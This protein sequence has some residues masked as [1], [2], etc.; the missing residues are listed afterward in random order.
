MFIAAFHQ[1]AE[2]PFTKQTTGDWTLGGICRPQFSSPAHKSLQAF[3]AREP[4]LVQIG[5]QDS[6]VALES[7]DV[8]TYLNLSVKCMIEMI[9]NGLVA[10]NH[11]A[12]YLPKT[13]E[14]LEPWNSIHNHS[15]G[16]ET[17]DVYGDLPVRPG[18]RKQ[19]SLPLV[20]IFLLPTPIPLHRPYQELGDGGLFD[21]TAVPQA[22]STRSG[23][24]RKPDVCCVAVVNGFNEQKRLWGGGRTLVASC[25]Y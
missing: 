24:A 19:T 13:L 9:L 21:E 8:D 2:S 22:R 15:T 11:P 1:T 6:K 7:L 5:G 14:A 18:T 25:Y 20:C 23:H 17:V 10:Q 12:I 4:D 3:L 16:K